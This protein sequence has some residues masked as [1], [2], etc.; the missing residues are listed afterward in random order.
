MNPSIGIR[1]DLSSIVSSLV[2]VRMCLL[3]SEFASELD[4]SSFF[5]FHLRSRS[6]RPSEGKINFRP[7]SYRFGHNGALRKRRGLPTCWGDSQFIEE[8]R[9]I[10]KY[11]PKPNTLQS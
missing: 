6:L 8:K 1:F 10:V 7:H 2:H 11:R 9:G 4:R 5:R 3:V